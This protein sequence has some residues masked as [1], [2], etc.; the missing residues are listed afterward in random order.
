MILIKIKKKPGILTSGEL[1]S[2]ES[3]ELE[4]KKLRSKLENMSVGEIICSAMSIVFGN[5]VVSFGD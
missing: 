2:L 5:K 3:K 4:S 1:E